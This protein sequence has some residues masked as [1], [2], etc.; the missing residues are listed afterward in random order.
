MSN[1]DKRNIDSRRER[2]NRNTKD[3]YRILANI[4]GEESAKEK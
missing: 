2:G 1:A 4:V 3:L